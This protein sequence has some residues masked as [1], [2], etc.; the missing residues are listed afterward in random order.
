M[1]GLSRP[2]P[3][4]LHTALGSGKGSPEPGPFARPRSCRASTPTSRRIVQRERGAQMVAHYALRTFYRE[5]GQGG[6]AVG[7]EKPGEHLAGAVRPGLHF[8]LRPLVQGLVAVPDSVRHLAPEALAHS[9]PQRIVGKRD[10]VAI[11][12]LHSCINR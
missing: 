7:L 2:P 4:N 9:P 5:F 6:K 12:P 1:S 8:Q 10:G 3:L 11:R